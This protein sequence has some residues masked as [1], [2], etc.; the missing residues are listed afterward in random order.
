MVKYFSCPLLLFTTVFLAGC[1]RPPAP[2]AN[3][4]ALK[5]GVLSVAP[6]L[7]GKKAAFSICSDDGEIRCIKSQWTEQQPDV[8]YDGFYALGKKYRIPVTFFIM[9][10]YVSP[11]R[12]D[13]TPVKDLAGWRNSVSDWEDWRF[14]QQQGHEISSHTFSHGDFRPDSIRLNLKDGIERPP[15]VPYDEFQRPIDSLA[16]YLGEKPLAVQIPY[17]GVEERFVDSA[18]RY[19][20]IVMVDVSR[21]TAQVL[22]AGFGATTTAAGLKERLA[23]ALA[24]GKWCRL[25]GHGI[26]TELGRREEAEY[27]FPPNSL[28]WKLR[29]IKRYDG[30]TPVEYAVLDEFFQEVD[31]QRGQL[32]IGPVKN[33]ARYLWERKSV[34]LAVAADRRE[35][36]VVRLEHGL[37]PAVFNYPLTLI[38][39]PRGKSPAP[40]ISQNGKALAVTE[41]DGKFLFNAVPQQG[42]ITLEL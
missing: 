19:Y 23:Q 36:A 4:V 25:V 39:Q 15:G 32:F 42:E 17:G 2:P 6:W 3:R 38:F 30:T 24:Q 41:K 20:P 8:A 35:K 27:S 21:D 29:K 12:L 22:A 16:K 37:D 13:Y 18:R 9:P 31:R 1:S 33:V 26:R 5:I 28:E 10:K 7:D 11:R 34:R 14:M 40:K